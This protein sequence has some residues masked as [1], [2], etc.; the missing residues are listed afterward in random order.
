MFKIIY[1]QVKHCYQNFSKVYTYECTKLSN[2]KILSPPT[3]EHTQPNKHMKIAFIFF[4]RMFLLNETFYQT[5]ITNFCKYFIFFYQKKIFYLFY[6]VFYNIYATCRYMRPFITLLPCSSNTQ[7]VHAPSCRQIFHTLNKSFH[8]WYI[9]CKYNSAHEF[10][11][12]VVKLA[13][14]VPSTIV[15]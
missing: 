9:R 15:D 3:I 5:S 14:F 4:V 12:L 10:F 1:I 13:K 8:F 11:W 2:D 7:F 6:D